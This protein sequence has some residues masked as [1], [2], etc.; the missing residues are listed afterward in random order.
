MPILRMDDIRDMDTEERQE[1]LQEFRTELIKIKTMIRAG[2]SVENPGR[3][4][5]LRKTIARILTVMNEEGQ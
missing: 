2:G 3:V 4:K 1:R 5:A